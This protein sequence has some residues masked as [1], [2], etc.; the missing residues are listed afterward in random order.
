VRKPNA[1]TS[2]KHRRPPFRQHKPQPK[3]QPPPAPAGLPAREAAVRLLTNVLGDGHAF[4][5]AMAK[6]FQASALEPRDRALARLIAATVLRR[7]GQLE[8]VLN[9]YLEKPLPKQKGALWPILL[10][11]AAQLLFLETPPHAAVGL[12]VDQV[13]K[14]RHAGRYD[15]LANALL[16]RVARE[17]AATLQAKGG[18]ALDIPPWLLQRWTKEY[19][20]ET[21]QRIAVAS[22]A[23]APLDLSVKD[24]PEMWAERLGGRALSTGT[25]RLAAGGRIEDLAGYAEGNWWV[26][27]AAAALPARLLGAVAGKTVVDMCAAPGGKTAQLA[28]AGAKVTAIDL[29]G[30][31]LQRLA[32]NLER[33]QMTAELVEADAAAW[34]PSRTFDA[35]LLDAPCTAT[36]TI[37][38]HPDIL[39]LKRPADVAA[40]ADIQARLLDNA[41]KRV[42]PGGTLLY[43]TC[44]LEPEEGA[45]QIER[46]LARN[47]D[48]ARSPIA[49]G[50]SGIA[51]EWLTPGGDLRT[52][53]FHL[54]GET[55]QLSGMDGFYAARL[56]RT[57]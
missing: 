53:P 11:G 29:S 28:A 27:D 6:E 8:A 1:P 20:A 42:A 7:L 16:R 5:G 21:A 57:A 32:A 14:D 39:R 23:E 19:G 33:L 18:V 55:P 2:N 52:L 22:L 15:K 30:S 37:R 13:R 44:S 4:D 3:P 35:V 54:A 36:G 40:L 12:A 47:T 25:V 17:G 24:R 34:A 9:S 43:C 48:F 50:E 51:P 45:Q 10:S 56:I 49:A 46:F 41:A 38:R 26:Q 31:R